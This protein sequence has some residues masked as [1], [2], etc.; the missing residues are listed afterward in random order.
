[1][2]IMPMIRVD[3]EV[4]QH[5]NERGNTEDTFND[6]IRRELGLPPRKPSRAV[7]RGDSETMPSTATASGEYPPT[8]IAALDKHLPHHWS[9]TRAR[10]EQ[11]LDVF[12][13]FLGMPKDWGIT[14]RHLAAC[15]IVARQRGVTIQTVEDKCGR[16][17]YGQGQLMQQFRAALEAAEAELEE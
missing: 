1:M 5:L 4:Y 12:A 11:I 14:K 16:Q 7:T 10:R 9:D 8:S 17:L 2:Q 13:A 15:K 3:D 6:V